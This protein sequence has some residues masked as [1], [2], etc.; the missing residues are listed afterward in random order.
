MDPCKHSPSA[1]VGTRA[2]SVGKHVA[3]KRVRARARGGNAAPRKIL[4]KLSL[5]T[6]PPR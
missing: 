6:R 2:G 3:R 4:C 5:E 1:C